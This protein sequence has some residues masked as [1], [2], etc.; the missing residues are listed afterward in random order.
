MAWMRWLRGLKRQSSSPLRSQL[1]KPEVEALEARW[2]PYTKQFNVATGELT[3]L[4]SGAAA[5]S[6]TV[7][8]TKLD[9]RIRINNQLVIDVNGQ[10]AN[11]EV[12]LSQVN[13]L[14]L[15]GGAG[16][17]TLTINA[18]NDG[19]VGKVLRIDGNGGDDLLS[20]NALDHAF[21]E[22]NGG[23]GND[24]LI[25][26]AGSDT[27]RGN[28]GLDS[29]NG[30]DG[31]D[32]LDGGDGNDTIQGGLGDDY[33]QGSQGD[34]SLDGGSGNDALDGGDGLDTLL[35]VDGNDLLQGGN[36]NDKML[37]GIGNDTLVGGDGDD[38]L[39]GEAGDDSLEGGNGTDRFSFGNSWGHDIVTDAGPAL[40]GTPAFTDGD[41]LLFGEVTSDLSFDISKGGVT[42][43]EAG[44]GLILDPSTVTHKGNALE[45]LG[46]GDGNDVFHMLELPATPIALYGETGVNTLD[47]S[48]L[49]TGVTVNL[50][51]LWLTLDKFSFFQ[52]TATGTRG[53]GA[54]SH[55]RGSTGNDSLSGS[56]TDNR[57]E[58][59]LGNDTL[60]GSGGNDTLEG[61]AGND[62]LDGSVGSDTFL[63][64]GKNLGHDTITEM[65]G[66]IDR[67]LLDFSGF[68]AGNGSGI[69]LFLGITTAQNVSAGNLDLVFTSATSIESVIGTPF[70]DLLAGTTSADSLVGG[71]GN[72]TLTGGLGNDTLDG[73]NGTDRLTELGNVN[74]Q[75]SDTKLT[76]LGTDTLAG[77]EEANLSGGIGN[78]KL[79][80]GAF[81]GSVTLTGAAGNDTLTG[82]AGDDLLDGGMG[83]DQYVFLTSAALQTDRVAESANGGIDQLN[84][85]NLAAGDHLTVDLGSDLALAK[86][87]NRLVQTAQAGQ[88]AF[89]EQ[90]TGGA[91]NDSITGNAAANLLQGGLG[92]DWFQGM[93]GNDTLAGGLGDDTYAFGVAAAKQTVTVTE[94]ANQGADLLDFSA[95]PLTQAVK[96]NLGSDTLATAGNLTIKT[97]AL[98]QFA[99]WEQAT[100]GAGDDTIT[101]NAAANKLSGGL[102]NDALQGLG[103]SDALS[104]GDGNDTL[105]GGAGN[106]LI[107]GGLGTDRWVVNGTATGDALQAD[108]D[109]GS[110]RLIVERRALLANG[111]PG[112][113]ALENDQGSGIEDLTLNGLGG[114]DRLDGS[115][116]SKTDV[117]AAGLQHLFLSGGAGNDI[118]LGGAAIDRIVET[119]N[120]NFT[121]TST[122]LTGLGTDTLTGMDEAEL[123]GG[124]SNN[125]LDAAAF[126][127]NVTLRGGS[128]NDSLI[129]GSGNDLLDGGLGT[130]TL[131]GGSGTDVG[132]NG[133][134]QSG[135]P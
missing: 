102:G 36:G 63:F 134:S 37:G 66:G 73:G 70:D 97:A 92:N 113:A 61:G 107:D 78:N 65:G 42:V 114:N 48:N 135:I 126:T 108:W 124:I 3:I 57:I 15:L 21:Y 27:L 96:I 29:L 84:F 101:G 95:M 50:G 133:E 31:N 85:A 33:L 47:Y 105:E 16:N 28:E 6:I 75:L 125:K 4:V 41:A 8:T 87:T 69:T 24:T 58:G 76:G 10:G 88:A 67:D 117:T 104:G 121:L 35:G 116:L 49:A 5:E 11:H 39:W 60:Y 79:D 68:D 110:S 122:K 127:G 130:D 9:D 54:I 112:A 7:S 43:T 13:G 77:V 46:G 89:L 19:F 132:L 80:A 98:G 82:G 12:L 131:I 23:A 123:T 81:S 62:S 74:F 53:V 100:G 109:S 91:G 22:I 40:T 86:H 119:G 93:A 32:A 56:S 30:G 129:G 72:D 25:G 34:D 59:G 55:V 120:V 17:D 64:Q 38:L 18:D 52:G 115:A 44:P 20:V 128:G 45:F 103:N 106:D 94:L 99:Q 111:Q 83:N 14:Y 71:D 51:G 118:F 26:G 1:G 2:V 90:V